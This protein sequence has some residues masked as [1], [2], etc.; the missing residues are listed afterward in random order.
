M[1][2]FVVKT[3]AFR[4][5][6]NHTA[7]S[8]PACTL[9]SWEHYKR[10]EFPD[11]SKNLL[12]KFTDLTD[13]LSE[14]IQVALTIRSKTQLPDATVE[15]LCS[16]EGVLHTAENDRRSRLQKTTLLHYITRVNG[17]QRTF[18]SVWSL[19]S[20]KKRMSLMSLDLMCSSYMNWLKM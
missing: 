4:H 2:C 10:K 18:W 6:A 20:L 5:Q 7:V 16:L 1:C 15:L 17:D 3:F 9:W 11:A 13:E 14:L 8:I 12:T 19:V